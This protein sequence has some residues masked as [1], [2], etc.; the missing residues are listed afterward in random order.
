[1]PTFAPPMQT[2]IE[3]EKRA[4]TYGIEAVS[5]NGSGVFAMASMG[6]APD[7]SPGGRRK[8]AAAGIDVGLTV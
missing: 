8:P 2:H 6:P 1:M 3:G 7:Q 5:F 4:M